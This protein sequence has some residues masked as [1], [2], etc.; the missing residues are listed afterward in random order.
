[1]NREWD[2]YIVS[3]YDPEIGGDPVRYPNVRAVSADHAKRQGKDAYTG[4]LGNWE[5]IQ[6]RLEV[7]VVK[8]P[9]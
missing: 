2:T 1:M 3:V 9:R 4:L 8:C 7:S 6:D 5:E